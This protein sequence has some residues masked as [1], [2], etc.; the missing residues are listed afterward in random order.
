MALLLNVK[1]LPTLFQRPCYLGFG[2]LEN[3]RI[4][5]WTRASSTGFDH[6]PSCLTDDPTMKPSA[7]SYRRI[8][9]GVMPE[10]TSVGMETA[11]LTERTS[12]GSVA[13]PVATPDTMTPSARKN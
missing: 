5:A 6:S 11:W 7:A 4:T 8:F 10:P 9:S 12:F 1:T 2:S 3:A 13:L